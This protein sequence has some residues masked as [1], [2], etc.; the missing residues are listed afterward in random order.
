MRRG[1]SGGRQKTGVSFRAIAS[2][3]SRSNGETRDNGK[4][5]GVS[6]VMESALASAFLPMWRLLVTW[7][8]VTVARIRFPQ[9]GGLVGNIK[10]P[11]WPSPPTSRHWSGSRNYP[12]MGELG[13][14][15]LSIQCPFFE[16]KCQ[17]RKG[18]AFRVVPVLL[19]LSRM[20]NQF[21]I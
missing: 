6:V 14:R 18:N 8:S 12:Q 9:E 15:H 13:I 19:G 16:R 20:P 3:C 7:R 2:L 11:H 1:R 21:A 10:G 17:H 5:G 4:G